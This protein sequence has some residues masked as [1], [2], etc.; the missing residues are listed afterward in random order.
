MK[1]L[2]CGL[3]N[4]FLNL[5]C[6]GCGAFQPDEIIETEAPHTR[7]LPF[8]F[9]GN[10]REYFKIW[11][12]NISLTILTLGIYSAWAKVRTKRY[13]YGNTLLDGISFEYL[14]DPMKI[15]KGRLIV[16]GIFAL[17][18]VMAVFLPAVQT[19]SGFLSLVLLP[20]L[21]VKGRTFNTRN[22]SF[23]N[24]RFDFRVTYGEAYKIFFGLLLLAS[25]TGGLAYPYFAFRR[26]AFL[27]DHSKYGTTPFK[28]DMRVSWK[29]FYAIYIKSALL[30]IVLF[31]GGAL[32]MVILP[33]VMPPP[34]NPNIFF[35]LLLLLLY[36]SVLAYQKTLITNLVWSNLVIGNSRFES[37][38]HAGRMI[39][40]YLS[41]ALAI[42]MSL[43]LLIPWV[44]IRMT[45]YRLDHITLWA[46]GDLDEFIASQQSEVSAAGE[47]IS[48]FFDIDVGI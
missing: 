37:T 34:I 13:F 23:R 47:E 41:N 27:I 43:G 44:R 29:D 28:F 7:F 4:P 18:V 39:K 24:I 9:T 38:L 16:L 25:L 5:R 15:L 42:L 36:L 31:V 21:V 1:C 26:N 12:V 33:R 30:A 8:E 19:I 17:Y 11:I 6:D 14:G 22:S 46:V 48:E 10:T 40:L 2:K 20:W 35:P 45:R 3:D 32:I